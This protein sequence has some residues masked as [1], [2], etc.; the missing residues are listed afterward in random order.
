MISAVATYLTIAIMGISVATLLM[1]LCA[2]LAGIENV[3]LRN[4]LMAAAGFGLPV[5]AALP[6][7]LNSGSLATML[8]LLA[9]AVVLG[10]VIIRAAYSTTWGKALLTWIMHLCVWVLLSSL[11]VH[12]KQ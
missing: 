1:W 12:M 4:S 10:L 6:V 3:D 9:S 7:N 11:V 8:L 2:R 5:A